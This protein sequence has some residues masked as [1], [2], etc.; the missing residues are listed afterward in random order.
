MDGRVFNFAV[1]VEKRAEHFAVAQTS[2]IFIIYAEVGSQQEGATFEV[3]LPVTS[4]GKGNLVVGKRGI[5]QDVDNREWNARIVQII[6][7]PISLNEAMVA[8]FR[9]IAQVITGKIEQISSAASKKLE[10]VTQQ[11]VSQV[12]P[13]AGQTPS[14]P[15][16]SRGI[17]AGGVLAGGGV[18]LAALGSS[19]AYIAKVVADHGLLIIFGGIAGAVLAFLLPTLLMAFIKLRRRDLSALLE[20][21]GWAVNA[22]MRLTQHQSK[23]F[24]QRPPYPQNAVGIPKSRLFLKILILLLLVCLIVALLILT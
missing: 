24:T 19:L 8:P 22:R 10:T 21:S 2:N 4:G 11:A 23:Y 16:P 3:A 1:R 14:Q 15:P 7:N 13:P 9:K 5:F 20:A 12:K 6:E 18:A 17:L